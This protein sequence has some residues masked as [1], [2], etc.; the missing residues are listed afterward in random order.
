M[1]DKPLCTFSGKFGDILFSLA[2]VRLVAEREQTPVDFIC[3]PAYKSLLPLVRK[4]SYICHAVTEP[5]WIT[6][7]SP[8][9][10]QPWKPPALLEVGRNKV[11]HLTYRRHPM[12]Q[13][14]TL[15]DAIAKNAVVNLR[16]EPWI[17]VDRGKWKKHKPMVCWSFNDDPT[18]GQKLAFIQ[19]LRTRFP[20]LSFVSVDWHHV[21]DW[22]DAAQIIQESLFF[23]GDMS[24]MHVLAHAIGK[25]CLIYEPSLDRRVSNYRIYQY[26]FG[27]EVVPDIG[28][29]EMFARTIEEWSETNGNS[30]SDTGGGSGP[31]HDIDAEAASVS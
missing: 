29:M 22:I 14:I 12:T 1:C 10:D 26:R 28:N 4:Q 6:T 3:M 20:K 21:P 17:K 25:R 19:S 5:S 23:I 9:G 30:M 18:R 13:G 8:F 11:Y 7:G 15:A 27:T 24:A 2:T 31:V 16:P